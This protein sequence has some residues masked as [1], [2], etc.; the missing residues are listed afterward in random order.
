MLF[1]RLPLVRRGQMH[2]KTLK[3][4]LIV[5]IGGA[6]YGVMATTVKFAYNDGFNWTQTVA[7]QA[8]FGTLY[9]A[10]AL[11]VS[12]LFGKRPQRV[13]AHQVARLLGTGIVACTTTVLYGFSLTMLPVAVSITLMFQFTWIGIVI[14]VIAT[15]RKPHVSEITAAVIIFFGTLLASGLLSNEFYTSLNPIGVACALLSSVS[16]AIFM[17]LTSKVETNMPLLQRGFFTCCGAAILGFIICPDYLTSGVLFE[18]IW[19][20]GLI[21]GFFGLFIPV[22]FFGIATPHLPAGLSTIMASS[23]L[24]CAIII[25]VFILQEAVELLQIIGIIVM[26]GGVVISQLPHLIRKTIPQTT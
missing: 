19:R 5:F 8:V 6:S 12:F 21:L 15:R 20:Y 22:I 16:C 7:S 25:S 14:Q 23:E 9:F 17:F 26:L 4:S 1:P 13:R 18:G 10:A 24:P 11:L 3:Y 2:L